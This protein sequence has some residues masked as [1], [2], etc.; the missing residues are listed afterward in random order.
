MRAR[1]SAVRGSGT[2][3]RAAGS[4]RR[5]CRS[6]HPRATALARP[7]RQRVRLG[8]FHHAPSGVGRPLPAL[9]ARQGARWLVGHQCDG[10]PAR[11]QLGLRCLGGGRQFRLEL[12]LHAP[13][14]QAKRGFRRRCRRLSRR[15]R[16]DRRGAGGTRPAQSG[17]RL[18]SAR[19]VRSRI[20]L[21]RGPQRRVHDGWRLE[22]V[23]HP[24][25]R[26]PEHGALLS[27]AGTAPT[28]PPR[29]H[30][31]CGTSPGDCRRKVRG[32]PHA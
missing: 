19:R 13:L 17:G 6:A 14:V 29:H 4:R 15:W 16:S 27:R 30:R 26:P 23:R 20:R 18:L 8:L 24:R 10:P 21:H 32:C 5:G 2:Q 1:Q 3:R 12:R 7:A 9:S 31:H 22:P 28:Q 11:A 25:W